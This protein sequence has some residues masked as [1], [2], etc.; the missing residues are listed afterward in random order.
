[1]A[2][3][4]EQVNPMAL[5]AAAYAELEKHLSQNGEAG[6]RVLDIIS[7]WATPMYR[8]SMPGASIVSRAPYWGTIKDMV[9]L[10]VEKIPGLK[11]PELIANNLREV[12][13]QRG[14]PRMNLGNLTA[15]PT[16]GANLGQFGSL[17]R[18]SGPI[19]IGGMTAVHDYQKNRKLP[20]A[21]VVGTLAGVGAF[22]GG[23]AVGASGKAACAPLGPAAA[24]VCQ[25]AGETVG[26]MAGGLFGQEAAQYILGR[27]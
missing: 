3:Q 26:A 13:A 11:V 2:P 22:A 8:H 23:M 9:V 10:A 19:G 21:L 16:P 7:Q 4:P 18:F 27:K 17:A 15:P 20:E 5:R 14:V 1:M 25:T 6:R 24:V 12:S